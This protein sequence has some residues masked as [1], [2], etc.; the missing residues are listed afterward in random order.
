[1]PAMQRGQ[2]YRLERNR[3]GLRYYD[4]D[5][6]RRRTDEKFPSKSAA[7]AHYREV[8]EPMLNGATSRP[9]SPST[10]SPTSSSSATRATSGRAQSPPWPTA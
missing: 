8:I 2:A 7:L 6:K 1:M 3:W 5:G 9:S 4:R 10:S